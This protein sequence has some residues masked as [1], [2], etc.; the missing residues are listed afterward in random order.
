MRVWRFAL[1]VLIGTFVVALG[2]GSA[3]AQAKPPG[4]PPDVDPESGF[5]LPL[6]QRDELDPDAQRVYDRLRDPSGGSLAG[7]RGP[8]GIL[9][10]DSKLSSLNNALNQYLRNGAGLSG[11]VREV[12]ILVTAREFDSQFEWAAH[13]PEA[14]KE[15]VPQAAIDAIK[16]RTGLAKLDPEDAAI[17]ALGR[18]MFGAKHVSS[19][20]FARALQQFGKR[21]LIDVIALMGNYAGTAALLTAFD[22]QLNPGQKP[23]LPL[24]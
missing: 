7:L 9:L 16:H 13:E 21:G 23:L 11:H 12:A 17:V 22:T 20:T 15:G 18:E 8:G 3:S 19:K 2:A 5:R 14:I 24:P 6:P 10:Y 4:A 1:M